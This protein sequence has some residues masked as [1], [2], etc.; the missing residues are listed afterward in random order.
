M[1]YLLKQTTINTVTTAEI[2]EQNYDLNAL[3]QQMLIVH[4]DAL[5]KNKNATRIQITDQLVIGYALHHAEQ[6]IIYYII[7]ENNRIVSRKDLK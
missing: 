1:Y 7:D 2:I 3:Y 5:A 6:A 4:T